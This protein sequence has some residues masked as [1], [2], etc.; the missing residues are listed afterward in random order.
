MQSWS[1]STTISVVSKKIKFKN[2]DRQTDSITPRAN[3]TTLTQS[4]SNKRQKL[5]SF[6]SSLVMNKCIAFLICITRTNW[7]KRIRIN[8]IETFLSNIERLIPKTTQLRR[9]KCALG[10]LHVKTA[11]VSRYWQGSLI[12]KKSDIS[13][14]DGIVIQHNE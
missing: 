3:G 7:S 4:E 11:E 13:K 1:C 14:M 6:P 5:H 9:K 12:I 10:R 8:A 2:H